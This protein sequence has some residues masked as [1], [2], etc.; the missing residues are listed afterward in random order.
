MRSAFAA[1][2][3]AGSTSTI[4]KSPN[5]SAVVHARFISNTPS[6]TALTADLDAGSR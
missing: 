3:S 1:N 4:V 2:G 6:A 5:A